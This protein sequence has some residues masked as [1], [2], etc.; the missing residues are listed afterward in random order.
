MNRILVRTILAAALLGNFPVGVFTQQ[1]NPSDRSASEARFLT[2][3]P[4]ARDY[5]P[6]FSP[7]GKTVL[8]SRTSDGGKTWELFV[9]P[10]SG[11]EAH[12]LTHSPLPVSATRAS[13]SRRKNMIAFTGTPKD[14]DV[15]G[16]KSTIWLIN[17]DGTQPRQLSSTGLSDR[18]V[19]PSWYPDGESLAVMDVA[20]EVIKRIDRR[21]G[22]AV[23]VSNH[24]QVLTGMPSVSPDGQ[25]IAFAG[26]K[27]VGQAYDQAK[28]SIWLVSNTGDLRNL[29]ATPSQGRTPAWSPDG[30][31]LA[32]ESDRD[33]PNQLY[34]AFII[35]R[36]GTGLRRVTPYELDANHPVWS[37]DAKHLVF[38]ARYTKDKNTTGIA[39]MDVTKP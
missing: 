36:N 17:R 5:W 16:G 1:L 38:S 19:Y 15:R 33:S 24:E 32:F 3:D 4:S 27:N 35:N 26:Q 20:D 9:V 11:G 28:N 13:W 34:A 31:W 8:F 21:R 12:R 6:C 2:V 39:I 14:Q 23:T 30:Q 37:P 22:T 25:W 29:E 7:D 18:V 10:T